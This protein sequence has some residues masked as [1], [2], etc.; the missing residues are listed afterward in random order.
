MRF[1]SCRLVSFRLKFLR[2]CDQIVPGGEVQDPPEA[3]LGSSSG[4][5]QKKEQRMHK[6]RQVRYTRVVGK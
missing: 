1:V 2:K 5:L 3:R 6:R 4:D